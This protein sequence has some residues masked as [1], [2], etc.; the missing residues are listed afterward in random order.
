MAFSFCAKFQKERESELPDPVSPRKST[1]DSPLWPMTSL[2]FFLS[3]LY[4]RH[5]FLPV[6]H[7]TNLVQIAL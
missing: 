5:E 4:I 2:T 6:T 1:V 7:A 3:Y